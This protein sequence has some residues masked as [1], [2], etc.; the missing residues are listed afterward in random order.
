MRTNLLRLLF[1]VSVMLQTHVAL[2]AEVSSAVFTAGAAARDITPEPGLAMAGYSARE[3]VSAGTRDP[4]QAKAIVFGDGKQRVALVQIDWIGPPGTELRDEIAREVKTRAGVDC[5]LVVSTHTHSGPATPRGLSAEKLNALPHVAGMKKGV[6]EAVVDAAQ[7]AAPARVAVGRG[8]CRIAHNRRAVRPDGS[9]HMLW[10]NMER[11]P[12][13]PVDPEVG[14][15]RIESADG[16][17]VIATVVC[18]ACHPVVFGEDHMNYSAGYVGEM[19]RNVEARQG[20]LCIF[21]QG[22]AGDLNP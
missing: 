10:A 19:A 5:V 17:A 13:A 18:F 20:G 22:A 2:G 8:T 11:I 15:I 9:V 16:S 6:I 3:G 1:A 4:L 12:T 21:L 14:V 7:R